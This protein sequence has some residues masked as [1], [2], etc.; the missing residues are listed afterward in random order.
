MMTSNKPAIL[1]GKAFF[2]ITIPITKPTV[3]HSNLLAHRLKTVLNRKVITNG[4][5]VRLFE[6]R[7][8]KA[9]GVKHAIALNSCTS[10][11]MLCLN[12]L[13]LQGQVIV[14]SFTF[15][16]TGH[17]IVWNGLEPVFADCDPIT[18]N[19]DPKSVEAV[20]SEQT[21]AIL[22]THIFGNPADVIALKKIADR[23]KI[24]LIFDAAHGMGAKLDG[25]RLGSCGDAESFSLSP[26]KLLTSGEGGLL[27][28]EDAELAHD[29][30]LGRNYGDPGNYNCEF[31]GLSARMSEFNAII[32][33][34]S[35][36]TLEKNVTKRNQLAELYKKLLRKIPGISFQHI[37]SLNRS[38]YK[39]FSILIDESLFGMNR[40]MLAL[41]LSK[42]N[43]SVKKYFYPPLHKQ[44]AFEKWGNRYQNQLPITE[45]ISKSILSLP[46]FSHMD[47]DIAEHITNAIQRIHVF[48]VEIKN[49]LL[50]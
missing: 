34:E 23:H 35:L 45:K 11:L 33:L 22:A 21:S 18:F 40:D 16:A 30:Q 48:N 24:K 17:A 7:M 38:S 42:E 50:G 2:N 41:A 19:L 25:K 13:K 27:T 28:T 39:D 15:S 3:S 29:I 5:Y 37:S 26:T 8:K 49:K 14:P 10:G 32:G 46:L 47:E 44:T 1:G 20:L 43:I 31:S 12:R 36:K 9:L 4:P 6:E